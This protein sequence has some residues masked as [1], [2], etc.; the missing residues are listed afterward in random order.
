LFFR[1]PGPL[2]VRYNTIRNVFRGLP[3]LKK[4]VV[5]AAALA[6]LL[7]ISARATDVGV[8][9]Q[10]SQPGVYGRVDI[11]RFPQPQ[12]VVAQPVIVA[13]PRVVVAQPQPVYM[14]VPPGHQKKWKKHCARYNA[15]GVPVYFVDDRWYQD[16]VKHHK[17][18][19]KGH[20]KSRGKGHGKHGD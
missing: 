18:H 7:P 15:C 8:S 5:S 1:Q 17:D 14:W 10:V 11:G 13:Q 19:D 2:P 9:I 6:A 16:N 4:I 3:M 12:V 20:G